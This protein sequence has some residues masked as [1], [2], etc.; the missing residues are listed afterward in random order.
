MYSDV[1]PIHAKWFKEFGKVDV[2]FA[3]DIVAGFVP[4]TSMVPSSLKKLGNTQHN[5]L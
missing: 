5:G 4:L 2:N 1:G 3:K